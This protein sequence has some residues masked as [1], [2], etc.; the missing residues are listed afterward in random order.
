MAMAG[1]SALTINSEQRTRRIRL[2]TSLA[3]YG[4][5]LGAASA[6][7]L[8][9][10]R[11]PWYVEP[12]HMPLIP[13]F[14]ISLSGGIAGVLV[15]LPLGYLIGARA[16]E[17]SSLPRWWVIGLAFGLLL[18]FVTGALFPL[19]LVFVNLSLGVIQ[20]SDLIGQILDAGIRAPLSTVVNGGA[21]LYTG[22]LAGALF[23]TGGWAVNMFNAST[24]PVASRIGP[25]AIVLV[26][27]GMVVVIALFGSP[28]ALVKLG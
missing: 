10:E 28:D 6:L 17:S 8:E 3:L 1:L 7:I 4:G 25:W 26:L 22:L 19:S 11:K 23:G 5:A 24:R 20:S 2:M 16:T 15:A 21:G 27:G 18:P 13:S 9:L 14:F 12:E